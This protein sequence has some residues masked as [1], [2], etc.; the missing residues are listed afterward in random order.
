MPCGN[1]TI[2]KTEQKYSLSGSTIPETEQKYS[3][4]G[5]TIPKTEQKYSLSG[6]TIPKTEQLCYVLG[7]DTS[8][9]ITELF[10]FRT[11]ALWE[12]ELFYKILMRRWAPNLEF[13]FF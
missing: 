13:I 5:S 12:K 10:C 9:S 7:I 2:P 11:K 8:E 1:L 4:S 6:S 3:L